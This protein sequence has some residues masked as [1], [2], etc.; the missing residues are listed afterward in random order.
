MEEQI[1]KLRK[2]RVCKSE[3]KVKDNKYPGCCSDLCKR[4]RIGFLK[5][6]KALRKSIKVKHYE[7]S[8]GK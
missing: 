5:D 2:C 3:Y 1:E 4:K 6:R 7:S 8:L